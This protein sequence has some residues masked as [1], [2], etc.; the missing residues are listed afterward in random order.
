M[1]L[2]FSVKERIRA[3]PDRVFAVLTDLDAA[4][5]WM[6][7]YVSIEKLTPGGFAPG[8]RWRETRRLY[9]RQ[10]TEEFEVVACEPNSRIE[11]YIDGKKGSSRRGEIRFRYELTPAEK[12][13][14]VTLHG[15]IGG[16]GRFLE[17]IGRL[18]IGSF[19][20]ACLRDLQ[21]MRVYIES[22]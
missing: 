16:L 4:K 9:R 15:E 12:G 7:G 11:L 21:A 19:K 10:A 13:T 22:R 8:M 1:A 14:V 2:Q 18:F 5:A 3:A 17:W 20:T 6:P